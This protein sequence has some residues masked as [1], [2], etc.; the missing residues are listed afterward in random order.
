MIRTQRSTSILE[1]PRLRDEVEEKSA[2]IQ[3]L[4]SKNSEKEAL[5]SDYDEEIMKY[6]NIIKEK[7]I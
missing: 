6:K 2:Y 7:E 4:E 5:I 1:L 3:L